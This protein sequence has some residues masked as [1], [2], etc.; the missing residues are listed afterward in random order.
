MALLTTSSW[1]TKNYKNFKGHLQRLKGNC[2]RFTES[3]S[4]EPESL[5][6]SLY[7]LYHHSY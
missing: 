6:K 4:S 7:G 3:D 5:P 1:L 2:D